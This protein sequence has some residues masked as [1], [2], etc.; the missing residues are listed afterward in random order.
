MIENMKTMLDCLR[1]RNAGEEAVAEYKSLEPMLKE[2]WEKGA[3]SVRDVMETINFA[4]GTYPGGIPNNPSP[5]RSMLVGGL[6][7]SAAGYGVGWLGEK[8]TPDTWKRNRLRWTMAMLGAGLGATPGLTWGVIN[9]ANNKPFDDT[10]LIQNVAGYPY[11]APNYEKI[12]AAVAEY[13]RER[14][15]SI[16]TE[17]FAKIAQEMYASTPLYGM[18][19]IAAPPVPVDTFNRV[20]WTDPRVSNRLSPATRGAATGLM[21]AAANLPGKLQTRFVTPFDVARIAAGMGSG[22]L[23]GKLVGKGLGLLMGM[24]EETQEKLKNTGM[25]AGIIANLVPMA[26]GG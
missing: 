7:G 10:D 6:L 15:V 22:Y 19:G 18:A 23:S 3:L 12:G 17:R 13:N 8:W 14:G 9:K 11:D 5:L 24:P 20:L 2:A 25:F 1:W 4:P 16:D 26:F 21:T